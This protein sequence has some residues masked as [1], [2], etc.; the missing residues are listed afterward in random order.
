MKLGTRGPGRNGFVGGDSFWRKIF[1]SDKVTLMI[2]QEM[3][4][5]RRTTT[6]S[7]ERTAAEARPRTLGLARTQWSSLAVELVL[8][9]A[10]WKVLSL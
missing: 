1:V 6:A 9:E 8:S 4:L 10:E 5:R 2:K 7:W 3:R